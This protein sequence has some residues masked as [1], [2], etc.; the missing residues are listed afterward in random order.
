MLKRWK[1]L[2]IDELVSHGYG[3]DVCHQLP[4]MIVI[5]VYLEKSLVLYAGGKDWKTAKE[6]LYQGVLQSDTMQSVLSWY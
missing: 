3:V 2:V 1:R 5:K 4:E 6:S